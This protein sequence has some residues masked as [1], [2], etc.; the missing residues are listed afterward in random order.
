MGD[1]P[2]D[3]AHTGLTA[4]ARMPASQV[5]VSTFERFR[6]QAK[7]AVRAWLE[8]LVDADLLAVV[9]EHVEDLALVTVSGYR[10]AQLKTRDRGSWSAAKICGTG[11]AVHR[12][13]DSYKLAHEAGIV[14]SSEFEVW[15]EGPP[16]ED[17]AT[18]Q[19]FSD[20]TQATDELK[21][22]IRAFG[23]QGR[24]LADFLSRLSVKCQQPSRASVDAMNAWQMGAIWPAMTM[25]QI[26]LLYERLL[27]TAEA[28]QA[29]TSSP[30]SVRATIEL[31]RSSPGDADLWEPITAQVLSARM[32]R[33]LC[34]PLPTDTDVDLIARATAGQASVLEL[35]M[36]RAGASET[37]VRGALQARAEADAAAAGARAAGHMDRES[38]S[39]L[40]ARL[41]STATSITT[42]AQL[43]VSA[44][45]RP[46]EHIYHQLMGQAANTA[47]LD[48][49]NLY[50]RDHR[51]VVGHLCT[52]SDQCRFDWGTS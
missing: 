40:E 13:C 42:L 15:L 22:K 28:A 12:L 49:D 41:L 33:A 39:R 7:L 38:E 1:A 19:F 14:G 16:S 30:A 4:F 31:A 50:N 52:V 34:P 6:W 48:T 44:G 5:G 26:E 37:T 18:T 25:Q 17:R 43:G 24:Q 21:R 47:A 10:F 36:A 9:C 3:S 29:A 20:P 11:H 8:S 35:K 45:S 32:L 51:L 2:T 46:G 27:A 23:V